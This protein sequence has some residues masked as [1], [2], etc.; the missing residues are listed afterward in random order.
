MAFHDA[1][2]TPPEK[3]T[4][5]CFRFLP[6]SNDVCA[7]KSHILANEFRKIIQKNLMDSNLFVSVADLSNY[8]LVI[9]YQ[10]IL[11]KKKDYVYY[12]DK[13][14]ESQIGFLHDYHHFAKP[15]EFQR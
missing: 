5:S 11:V 8:L 6:K 2:P 7:A 10:K 12:I 1:S 13:K 15:F 9:L 3:Y 14:N 4:M